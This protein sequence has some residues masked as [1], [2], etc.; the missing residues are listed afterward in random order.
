MTIKLW[1]VKEVVAT[2]VV[3]LVAQNTALAEAPVGA[4]TIQQPEAGFYSPSV[5][6][7]PVRT[8]FVPQSSAAFVLSAAFS[9]MLA[10]S[11]ITSESGAIPANTKL[12]S[13]KVKSNDIYVDLSREFLAGGGSASMIGRLN[14]VVYTATSLNPTGRVFISVEGQPLD[15]RNPL[16]GEGLMI[17]YPINRRELAEDFPMN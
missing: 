7:T 8:A 17:R 14:Q 5:N 15:E 13:L 1:P 11:S 12:L 16:A 2:I 6:R 10:T 4:M 3:L 9:Q